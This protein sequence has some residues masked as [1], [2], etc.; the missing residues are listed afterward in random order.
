MANKIPAPE[1][2]LDLWAISDD[3]FLKTPIPFRPNSYE[4]IHRAAH[5]AFTIA[6]LLEFVNR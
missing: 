6:K 1:I 4:S 5:G 3:I 2:R